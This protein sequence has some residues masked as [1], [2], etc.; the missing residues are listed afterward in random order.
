MRSSGFLLAMFIATTCHAFFVPLTTEDRVAQSDFIG[1]VDVA[2]ESADDTWISISIVQILKGKSG[3]GD[4]ISLFIGHDFE[5]RD[6]HLRKGRYLIFLAQ[7]DEDR[8]CTV[9]SC[10]DAF[11]IDGESIERWKA[12]TQEGGGRA[13]LEEA[14]AEIRSFLDA[15]KPGESSPRTQATPNRS[16]L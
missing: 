16:S 15:T 10:L 7:D 13:P 2:E 1:I 14:L 12:H 9:Q 3:K 8:W 6:P 11:R 4:T 5:E